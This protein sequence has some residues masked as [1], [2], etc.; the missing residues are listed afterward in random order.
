M[1]APSMQTGAA[2]M[3]SLSAVQPSGTTQLRERQTMP[4][5]GQ[6]ESAPQKRGGMQRESMQRKP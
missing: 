5:K 1:H 6:S 2:A 3:Q 4:G